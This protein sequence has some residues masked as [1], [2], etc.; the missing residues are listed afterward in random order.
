MIPTRVGLDGVAGRLRLRQVVGQEEGRVFVAQPRH[1]QLPYCAFVA[2]ELDP[3][4]DI[5]NLAALSLGLSDLATLPTVRGQAP[6]A[7]QHA[8]A[9]AADGDETDLALSQSVQDGI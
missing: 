8:R 1:D 3:F 9:A 4:I 2:V 5:L 6:R 7:C